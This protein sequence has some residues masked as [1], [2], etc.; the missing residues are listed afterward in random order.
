V[1]IFF[2]F[3]PSKIHVSPSSIVSFH[4]PP[5]WRL[6]SDWH[7]HSTMS[8]HASFSWRQDELAASVLS[9]G[10]AS[11]SRFLSR[12]KTEALNSHHYRRP[13]SQYSLPPTLHCY[14]KKVISILIILPTTQSRPNFTSSLA[15]VPHHWSFN[16]WRRSL[17]SP[18]H[19]H[20]SSVQRHPRWRISRSYFVFRTAY[21][22]VN[23][24][25]NILKSRNIMWGY[26]LVFR[27]HEAGRFY[28][29]SQ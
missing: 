16:R 24:H 4:S 23:S 15:R 11:S 5:Q 8:Y 6:S 17:L 27:I 10:N 12:A 18:S 28:I 29:T 3:R 9:S 2:I 7:H 21:R 1:W 25:K 20:R 13:S 14:K 19:A 26:K 22:L